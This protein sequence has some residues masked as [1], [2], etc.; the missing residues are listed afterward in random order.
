MSGENSTNGSQTTKVEEKDI[1]EKADELVHLIV[2]NDID[3]KSQKAVV[4]EKDIKD[5][6]HEVLHLILT[7]KFRYKPSIKLVARNDLIATV[8][9]SLVAV[10]GIVL[11]FFI[12]VKP[13]LLNNV[14]K[15][16]NSV[17][18]VTRT[19]N[20]KTTETTTKNSQST[21]KNSE[22]V[23]LAILGL[24]AITAGAGAVIACKQP[25]ALKDVI[26]NNQEDDI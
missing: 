15:V 25:T 20:K 1:K 22:N 7:A 11:P 13:Y 2:T 24:A 21:T 10:L 19:E 6:V 9:G 17:E 16:T 18:N 26:N 23:I 5:K 14:E 3:A 4:T 12:G 8:A